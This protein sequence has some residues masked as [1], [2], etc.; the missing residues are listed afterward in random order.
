MRWESETSAK[1]FLSTGGPIKCCEIA[2]KTSVASAMQNI[3]QASM[4]LIGGANHIFFQMI[5]CVN[6]NKND[7]K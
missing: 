6:N 5:L 7:I 2:V 4:N 1:A 3:V